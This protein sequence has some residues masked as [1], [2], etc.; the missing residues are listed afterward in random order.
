MKYTEGKVGRIFVVRLEDGDKL[1]EAIESFAQEN[2]VFRGMCILL[3]GI[4]DGGNIVVGPEDAESIPVVPMIFGLKGVHEICAVG[5]IFPDSH[6]KPRLHM[7]AA[8]GRQGKTRSGCIRPGIEVW[9][10]GEVIVLEITDNTG[11]RK[12][13]A[14]AG[15]SMLEP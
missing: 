15:F 10:L 6:G 14:E 1:P 11:H 13:D 9:K 4:R 5:T 8:L 7:H 12:E 2:Q 3:G